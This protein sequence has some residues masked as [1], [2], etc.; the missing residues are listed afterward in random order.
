M[1]T[2]VLRLGMNTTSFETGGKKAQATLAGITK[3]GFSTKAVLASLGVTL[4]AAGLVMALSSA[5]RGFIEFDQAMTSSLA[6]MGDVNTSMRREMIGTAREVAK[7]VNYSASQVGEAYYFLASAGLDAAQSVASMPAVAAFARAG[8]FDLAKATDLATDAQSALGLA[9]KDAQVNLHNMTRVTDVLVKANTLANASVEQFATALTSEAGAALK[10][11]GKDIEEGVAVLAAFADQG[12]KAEVAGSG[13]SRILRLMSSA[14]VNNA[15]AY[16]RLNIRV[17]DSQ[18]NMRNLADIIGDLEKTTASMSDQTRVAA[19]EQ[20]GFQ[21]RV[22]GVILPLLGTSEK[23]REYERALRDAA[24]TT[25]DVSDKQMLSLQNRLG[26]IGQSFKIWRDTMVEKMVP[27][28]ELFIENA[29]KVGDTLKALLVLLGVGAV[30]GVIYGFIALGPAVVGATMAFIALIPAVT[31]LSAAFAFLT[32]S[33]WPITAALA[34]ITAGIYLFMRAS[35]KARE[36]TEATAQVEIDAWTEKKVALS[37]LTEEQ[38]RATRASLE[39]AKASEGIRMRSGEAGKTPESMNASFK[40]MREIAALQEEINRLLREF[41][42]GGGAAGGEDAPAVLTDAQKASQKLVEDLEFQISAQERLLIATQEG[43]EALAETSRQVERETALREALA[44]ATDEDAQKVTLL[45]TSLSNLTEAT[46]DAQKAQEA[47]QASQDRERELTQLREMIAL[48]GV[49]QIALSRLNLEQEKA[50]QLAQASISMTKEE[51]AAYASYIDELYELK[52][53]LVVLQDEQKKY[54]TIADFQQQ[55]NDQQAL[56]AAQ[57]QGVEA[58]DTLTIAMAGEAAVMALGTE[59]TKAFKD[60][61]RELAEELARARIETQKNVE[62][63]KKLTEP[64]EEALREIHRTFSTTFDDIL[65]GRLTDFEDFSDRVLDIFV[66]LASEIAAVMTSEALGLDAVLEDLRAGKELSGAWGAVAKYG[67]GAVIG[68]GVGAQAGVGAGV[69]AGAASGAAMGGPWGALIGGMSGLVGGLLASDEKQRA[70]E[71]ERR[72]VIHENTLTLRELSDTIKGVSGLQVSDISAAGGLA[73]SLGH[74]AFQ[75]GESGLGKLGEYTRGEVVSSTDLFVKFK[76]ILD[77]SGSSLDDL[78]VIAEQTGIEIYDSAGRIIPGALLQLAEGAKLLIEQLEKAEA[79]FMRELDIRALYAQGLDAE[80]A[81]IEREIRYMAERKEAKD[82]GFSDDAIEHLKEV[83]RA[84]EMAGAMERLDA[85]AGS[86]LRNAEDAADAIQRAFE[87]AVDAANAAAEAALAAAETALEASRT[88]IAALMGR[89]Y[90]ATGNTRLGEDAAMAERH[91]KDLI[92][93]EEQGPAYKALLELIHGQ[94]IDRVA[95]NREAEAQADLLRDQIDNDREML[96]IAK[97]SLK[98]QE[99][100]VALSRMVVDALTDFSQSLVLGELSTLSPT[101]KYAEAR[102]QYTEQLTLAQGGDAGAAA[103]LPAYATAFL[104]ASREVN[105]S[106]IRYVADFAMVQDTIGAITTQ[107]ENQLS[108]DEQILSTLQRQVEVLEAG[109]EQAKADAE[110]QR[111][112][113]TEG[114][115]Q[116]QEDAAALLKEAQDKALIEA[117]VKWRD[118]SIAAI[119]IQIQALEDAKEKAIADAAIQIAA[120]DVATAQAEANRLGQVTL[121]QVLGASDEQISAYN[122]A[123]NK[124]LDTMDAQKGFINTSTELQI[125]AINDQITILE[126]QKTAIEQSAKDQIDAIID[127]TEALKDIVTELR[128]EP[129]IH[130]PPPL[131]PPPDDWTFALPSSD[132]EQFASIASSTKDTVQELKN[133]VTE[134]RAQ[135][136]LLRT[137]FGELSGKLTTLDTT[138]ENMAT[139]MKRAIEG[140]NFE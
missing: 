67:T 111:T 28:L 3:Q 139:S 128:K 99:R 60:Q 95:R 44:T 65:H 14:A 57:A 29:D 13:L 91:R 119:N 106:S 42:E 39:L 124:A 120:L 135:V 112:V 40:K 138:V 38:L 11:F 86:A 64:W 26:Q 83:Q 81:S 63:V 101:Q 68:A 98:A 117:I 1:T 93:A 130:P 19:L 103:G 16:E 82:K 108:V 51:Y 23:I 45:T 104:E 125:A 123:V 35:R 109:I 75:R 52:E 9:S 79:A 80:A 43:H 85:T 133:T 53:V 8:M 61:V 54:K 113:T 105:A 71:E 140:A 58:V 127:P 114:N 55:I 33:V 46:E 136:G 129:Y 73:S 21:A 2:E 121:L 70:I 94:E 88:S 59:A 31:S 7:E 90:S 100:T 132:S 126:A 107:F 78:R 137:G 84:E 24:G 134:L 62:E 37:G 15:E 41:G 87:A 30:G 12:V 66:K 48:Q 20:L 115:T 17:W 97:D 72:K 34:A 36:E 110:A 4:G 32:I 5:T 18:G 74:L 92:E 10:T 6:I 96:G 102:S 118:E 22:Q 27:V 77:A 50:N 76:A 47:L 116:A 56:T 89:G 49:G 69:L 25:Q 131:P 122:E